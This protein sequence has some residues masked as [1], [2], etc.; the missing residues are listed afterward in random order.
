MDTGFYYIYKSNV[1]ITAG[2]IQSSTYLGRVPFNFF[3]DYRFTY[4]SVDHAT[5][6]L[7]TND[8]P[9]TV[10]G[11]SQNVFVMNCTVQNATTYFAVRT[12]YG[13]TS[14]NWSVIPGANSIE[15]GFGVKQHLDPI[16]AYLQEANAQYPGSAN[17]ETIDVYIH[18]GSKIAVGSYPDMTNEGC[19]PFHFGIIKSGNVGGNNICMLK[20]HGGNGNFISNALSSVVANS[21]KISF[22]DWFPN[23]NLGDTGYNS[24]WFGYHEKFDVYNATTS[25]PTP[26]SGTVRSYTY[27]RVKWEFNW[28]KK[29]WPGTIDTNSVY[30]VGSSQGCAGVWLNSML[31]A[32]TFAAGNATDGKLNMDA[33]NDDNPE[34]KYNDTSNARIDIRVMWGNEDATNLITDVPKVGNPSQYYK[35]YDLTNIGTMLGTLKNYSLPYLAA[36]NGKEDATTCW[37]EKI[38]VYASVNTNLTGGRYY[39]DLRG[40]SG[41]VDNMWPPLAVTSMQRYRANLSYPAFSN[42]TLDGDPG[43]M[44]NPLPPYYDGDDIGAVNGNIDWV[45]ST[46][47]DSASVW[48]I[49]LFEFQVTLN[50]GSIFPPV[51]PNFA[52]SDVTIRR[53]QKFKNIPKNTQLCWTNTHNGNTQSGSLKVTYSGTIQK[54]I[55]MKGVKIYPD[56]NVL[57]IVYCDGQRQATTPFVPATLNE[58]IQIYPNPVADDFFASLKMDETSQVKIE[59]YNVLGEKI[60]TFFE[61]NLSEG[62]QVVPLKAT[63]FI[64]GIYFITISVNGQQHSFKVIKL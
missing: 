22:D 24:K 41:G 63:G 57:R 44:N 32:K 27:K 19:L 47:V 25:S 3:Y 53:A 40:H 34:C 1:P 7:V 30:L 42:C 20:F 56:G 26:T 49:R 13:K 17:G 33:P 62:T 36:I 45:D 2:N 18:Y 11:P 50:D 59:G 46:I 8:N 51:L 21:W 35:I 39:W 4:S 55:T 38:P 48:Q 16:R 12:D 31:D 60:A 15:D 23:F 37:E 52:K 28:I 6:Y 29:N 5:R 43:D 14:P 58:N 9:K 64:P 61:G 10:V 54:P